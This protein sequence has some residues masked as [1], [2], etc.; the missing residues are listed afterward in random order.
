MLRSG[1]QGLFELADASQVGECRRA[2]QALATSFGFDA[3]AAGRVAIVTSELAANVVRHGGGG[4]LLL[5]PLHLI[6]V[7]EVH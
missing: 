6:G 5:Q 1:A 2:A 4:Y 7:C 3:P